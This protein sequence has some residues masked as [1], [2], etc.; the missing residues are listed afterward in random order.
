MKD[1]LIY[2]YDALCGW[3]YGFSPVIEK[4]YNKYNDRIGFDVV[5][6]GMRLGDSAGPI[7]E[8]AGYIRKAHKD[9]ERISG[10]KF[11][12]AFLD[13]TLERGTAI[14]SSEKPAWALSVFKQYF[15]DKAVL[16]SG[17]IQRAIYV[18]GMEP[19]NVSAYGK[20]AAKFG[21]DA[22]EFTKKMHEP[23]ARLLAEKDFEQTALWDIGGFPSVIYEKEGRYFLIARGYASFDEVD[24]AIAGMLDE[25]GTAAH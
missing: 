10:V 19:D 18:D 17:E 5:S 4:L 9:V 11:G 7:S 14:F 25:K 2:V 23:A 8:I 6:G 3:C 24:A 12:E 21:I 20:Y 16:F 22:N 13:G 1:K 15:P